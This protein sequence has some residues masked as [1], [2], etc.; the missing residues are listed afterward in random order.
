VVAYGVVEEVVEYFYQHIPI[1][2]TTQATVYGVLQ[3]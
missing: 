2:T 3:D 1:P